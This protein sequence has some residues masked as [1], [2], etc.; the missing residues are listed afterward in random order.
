ML[1]NLSSTSNKLLAQLT[2]GLTKPWPSDGEYRA[3][4]GGFSRLAPL[5]DAGRYITKLP[6]AEHEA[7]EWQNLWTVF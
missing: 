6:E 4:Y 7:E 2:P 3:A 1:D 5:E